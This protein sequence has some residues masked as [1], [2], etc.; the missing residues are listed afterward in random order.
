M[1]LLI[2]TADRMPSDL[3]DMMN[4]SM[5]PGPHMGANPSPVNAYSLSGYIVRQSLVL[6]RG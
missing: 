5:D 2:W 6:G 3:E 1:S 4:T